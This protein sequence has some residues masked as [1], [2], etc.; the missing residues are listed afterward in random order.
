VHTNKGSGMSLKFEMVVAG[1]YNINQNNKM[2]GL[3]KKE[4]AS[5]WIMYKAT[6]AS[7]L[8][9]PVAVAKTLKAL[10]IEAETFF[11]ST[12]NQKEVQG[13]LDIS[14]K[15][16]QDAKSERYNLM[17]EMLERDTVIKFDEY[18]ID[19]DDYEVQSEPEFLTPEQVA[20][21]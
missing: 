5:K 7:V 19:F 6:N 8:G 16:V 11:V 12:D 4:N 1:Q 18:T 10:K 15:T 14:I 3:I 9:K 21:L 13:N 20:Y 17:K 2:I